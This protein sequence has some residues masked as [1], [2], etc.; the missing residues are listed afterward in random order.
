MPLV[1]HS[2]HQPFTMHTS[3][4]SSLAIGLLVGTVH[5][6]RIKNF[7]SRCTSFA[8]DLKLSNYSDFKVTIAEYLPAESILNLTAEGRDPSCSGFNDARPIPV[9]LCRLGLT[10]P[11]SNASEV[12]LETWLPENWSG[13]FLSVGNGGLAGCK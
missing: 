11:T 12:I 10:V 4:L 7:K 13:R 5:S 1:A 8:S 2:Y 9:N 3:F 6:T